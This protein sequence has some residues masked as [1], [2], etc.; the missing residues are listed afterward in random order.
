MVYS[1]YMDLL[2]I[3][4]LHDEDNP[5]VENIPHGV[6]AKSLDDAYMKIYVNDTLVRAECERYK[7]YN[8]P[9]MTVLEKNWN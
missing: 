2:Y 5:P 1:L 6:I 7:R 4:Y 3:Y 9:I 8:L